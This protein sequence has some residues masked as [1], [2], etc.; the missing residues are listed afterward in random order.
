[1]LMRLWT[2]AVLTFL[3][4]I[5]PVPETLLATEA[6]PFL[7]VVPGTT[8][9]AE[10][11]LTLGEPRGK[12]N[13]GADE[14]EQYEY[15]PPREAEIFEKLVIAYFTDTKQVARLDAYFKVPHPPE[16]I[17]AEM[18]LGNRVLTRD[19]PGG[20]EEEFYYPKFNGLILNA[21]A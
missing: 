13:A 21:K 5:A 18:Q 12:I 20:S 4:G 15:A 7:S 9:K 8:T 19:R 10:V 11:D 3:L 6:P 2:L 17:R 1:M 14:T 16:T